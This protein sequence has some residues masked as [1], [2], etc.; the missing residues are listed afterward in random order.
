MSDYLVTSTELTETADA[1]R[2]KTGD[3]NLIEWE[4]GTGFADAVAAIPSG[5]GGITWDDF[6]EGTI[7]AGQLTLNTQNDIRGH[8]F[9]SNKALTSVTIK[10]SHS[11]GA[12]CFY[13]NIELL[14]VIAPHVTGIGDSS[15]AYAT[16]NSANNK[17]QSIELPEVQ[18]VGARAF[19]N[20]N[21]LKGNLFFPEARSIGEAAFENMTPPYYG[22]PYN[23]K[24]VLPKLDVPTT[25]NRVNVFRN[26]GTDAIDLGENVKQIGSLWFY[27]SRPGGG[28]ALYPIII[29][30]SPTLVVAKDSSSIRAVYSSTKVYVPQ[31]LISS[32]EAATNWSTKGSIFHAIEGSEY[33]HYYANGVGVFQP[34]T[35]ALT[36]CSIDNSE[37][38]VSYGEAYEAIL[39]ADTGY[40]ISSVSVV[41]NSADVTT[42]AYNASTG[43]ISI[44][45]VNG[46]ITITASAA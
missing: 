6:L 32:Y 36:N 19:E 4:S 45:S 17:L 33:E 30:R 27:D 15:F 16:Y 41:M 1:I 26:T 23:R 8:A 34:I 28:G 37:T 22:P 9:Y 31:T 43:K 40:T 12:Y 39:S 14:S 24:I 20:C 2:A 29:L 46:P 7:P 42:T 11:I 5:G 10:N 35:T 18:T 25:Q 21:K 3:A 44:A 38:D 13:N